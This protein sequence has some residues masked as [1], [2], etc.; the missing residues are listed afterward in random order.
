MESLGDVVTAVVNRDDGGEGTNAQQAE[1]LR[2][3]VAQ[4]LVARRAAQL[5]AAALQELKGSYVASGEAT[6][7]A[8]ELQQRAAAAAE[9]QP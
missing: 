9:R 8:A 4:L 6:D 1:Q 3:A 7:F 2:D 5:Q